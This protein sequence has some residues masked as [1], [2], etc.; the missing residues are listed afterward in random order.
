MNQDEYAKL[1]GLTASAIKAGTKSMLH[2]HHAITERGRTEETD[3][4]RWGRLVHAAVLEPDAFAKRSTVW[5]GGRRSGKEWD[6]FAADHEPAWIVTASES[7]KL[8][9][10]R[11]ALHSNSDAQR[12]IRWAK[13]EQALQWTD[14]LYGAGKALCDGITE[15]ASGVSLVE[16]KTTS[17]IAPYGFAAQAYGLGYHLQL[18]W[19]A[20]GI[21]SALGKY[22]SNVWLIAQEAKPPFDVVVYNVPTALLFSAYEKCV[23][24]AARYRVHEMAG[25]F[26]GVADQ[27]LTFELPSYAGDGAA[28]LDMEGVEDASE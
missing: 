7:A 10:M 21:K 2:M 9:T 11:A 6:A 5:Q 26:P 16:Y 18:A 24:I 22:P 3:S 14:T 17:K 13:T 4:L 20:H 12:V 8:A 25:T 1:P 23:Q 27:V 19:Y 28:S 15:N